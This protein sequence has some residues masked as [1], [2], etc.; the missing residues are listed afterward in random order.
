MSLFDKGDG[1]GA[2]QEQATAVVKPLIPADAEERVQQAFKQ[3]NQI[4]REHI[5]TETGLRLSDGDSRFSIGVRIQQG[6]PTPLAELI[7]RYQDPVLWRLIVG[8]PKLG[9][10]IEG[11]NFLLKDWL[12]LEQWPYLPPVAKNGEP[13]LRRS[14]E[15]ADALQR[16]ALAQ[17]VRDQIKEINE[18]ILGAY[19]FPPGQDSWIELYWMPIAMIAAMLDVK[20]EDLTVVVLAHELTHGYT[21]LGKDIDGSRWERVAF[22]GTDVTVIEGLAQFYTEVVTEKLASRVP[23]PKAAF[24][25]LLELQSDPYVAFR[26]WMQ[27]DADKRGE[28]LRFTMVAARTRGAMKHA[29]WLKLLGETATSLQRS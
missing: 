17:E 28:T 14:L 1:Q 25:K 4:V 23:G 18:D 3:W 13:A 27:D 20:I 26:K 10:L 29:A 5:R 21:H 19:R 16:V 7:G 6:F 15:I 11:L 24:E 9:G 12:L 22:A 2:L 8:Q